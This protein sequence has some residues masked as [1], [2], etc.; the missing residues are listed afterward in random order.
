MA[1]EFKNGAATKIEK[2]F[3]ES[4]TRPEYLMNLA[5]YNKYSYSDNIEKGNNPFD[6]H[7][8]VADS[9]EVEHS[10]A[11][12]VVFVFEDGGFVDE[13]HVGNSFDL[14]TLLN[15]FCS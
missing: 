9:F 1:Y 8:F 13:Y 7:V 2:E 6:V 12:W 3:Y 15:T 14:V 4:G 11:R 5:G 10:S